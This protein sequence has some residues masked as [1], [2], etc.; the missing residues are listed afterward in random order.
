MI[1]RFRVKIGYNK[2]CYLL[3]LLKNLISAI[4][5]YFIIENKLEKD[6][7]LYSI[8][9]MSSSLSLL[10]IF[11]LLGFVLKYNKD[12]KYI[13]Q[14]LNSNK[15]SINNYILNRIGKF[16]YTWFF[17]V[18]KIIINVSYNFIVIKKDIKDIFRN[19]FITFQYYSFETLS[20]KMKSIKRHTFYY[21]LL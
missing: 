6:L 20:R 16:K 18:W 14:F 1:F 17:K 13:Y 3:I 11:S 10:F 5:N 21:V 8:M 7:F 9:L 2:S 12:I 19:K 4:K 15:R